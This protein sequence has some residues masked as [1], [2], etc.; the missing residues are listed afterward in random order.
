MIAEKDYTLIVYFIILIAIVCSIYAEYYLTKMF[1]PWIFSKGFKVINI[2]VDFSFM[3]I[4]KL[5]KVSRTKVG[6]LKV[7]D[8][9][10]VYFRFYRALFSLHVN[11][12]V[13]LKGI[14]KIVDNKVYLTARIPLFSSIFLTIWLL[15]LFG[16]FIF[17]LFIAESDKIFLMLFILLCFLFVFCLIV[18]GGFLLEKSRLMKALEE[19]KDLS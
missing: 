11:T 9:T 17:S 16:M 18:F 12:P 5:R 7:I 19:I 4:E 8:D 2:P 10:T 13:P 1:S 15:S 3:D 6:S 14:L